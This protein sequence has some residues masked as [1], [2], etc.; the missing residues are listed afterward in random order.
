MNLLDPIFLQD[1]Q[2]AILELQDALMFV[3]YFIL[4][5]GLIVKLVRVSDTD[6]DMMAMVKPIFVCFF[7]IALIATARFW[8]DGLDAGFSETAAWINED[9]GSEPFA[10]S[11]E[12]LNT[13]M[14]DPEAEGW[15]VD[16]IVNSIYLSI[17][18]GLAKLGIT[19]AALFQ[20]PF[21]I[22]Q[23]VLKWF[24]FLF[25][26]IGLSLLI[27]P[28]LGNIGVKL[29]SN[30]LAVMAWPIGFALTNLAAMGVINDFSTS[31]T[32]TGN[33]TGTA[34]YMMSF[35]SLIMGLMASLILVIG[36]LATP[37]IMFILFS[38]GAILQ[39]ITGAVTGATAF[40][41]YLGGSMGFRGQGDAAPK[42]ESPPS[43]PTAPA[44]A[45]P[46]GGI[47]GVGAGFMANESSPDYGGPSS[48]ELGPVFGR[49]Q[50]AAGQ[51]AQ[52]ALTGKSRPVLP[53][54]PEPGNPLLPSSPNDPSG[55]QHAA[56]LFALGATAKP[57]IDV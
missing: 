18:Y 27:F 54:P 10:V 7:L 39:G 3:P 56:R 41:T 31:S 4:I 44:P 1:Y 9:F 40:A 8:F 23:Y 20:I 38:S 21:F 52:R 22:L 17:V 14:E 50:Q 11:E 30:L 45:S 46:Y 25:L 29:I 43:G 6:A 51:D 28:S 34:L 5:A 33:D 2:D 35:G 57:V 24:G 15:G 55:S 48:T 36:T 47:G 49:G 32:F 19:L 26:P 12:L 53:A 16:R 37:T 13:V 42:S